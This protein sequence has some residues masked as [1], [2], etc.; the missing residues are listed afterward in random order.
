MKLVLYSQLWTPGGYC[1]TLVEQVNVGTWV[2]FGNSAGFVYVTSPG[3]GEW[4]DNVTSVT[5]GEDSRCGITSA[6]GECSFACSQKQ[7][8]SQTE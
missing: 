7:N 3:M 5:P 6:G 1:H 8:L 4:E 2:V